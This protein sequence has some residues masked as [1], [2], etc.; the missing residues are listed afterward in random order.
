[1]DIQVCLV[2]SP[3]DPDYLSIYLQNAQM[4]TRFHLLKALKFI[5]FQQMKNLLDTGQF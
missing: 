5:T 2:S 1:M 4:F 3:L